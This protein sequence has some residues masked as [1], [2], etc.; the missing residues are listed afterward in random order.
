MD[1]P[2]KQTAVITKG[3]DPIGPDARSMPVRPGDK[4]A[5]VAPYCRDMPFGSVVSIIRTGF[6]ILDQR[7][8]NRNASEPLAIFRHRSQVAL[9]R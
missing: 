1:T 2:V 9:L 7:Y 4:V 6:S 5:Y 8:K 3:D